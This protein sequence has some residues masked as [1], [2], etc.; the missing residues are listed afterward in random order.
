MSS[1][2]SNAAAI[3]FAA[4]LAIASAPYSLV[5]ML[6]ETLLHSVM[7]RFQTD[8][9]TDAMS[10]RNWPTRSQATS[11]SRTS[12]SAITVPLLPALGL[13]RRLSALAHGLGAI[14]VGLQPARHRRGREVVEHLA[15]VHPARRVRVRGAV[16]ELQDLARGHAPAVVAQRARHEVAAVDEDATGPG[17]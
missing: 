16:A 1:T 8:C 17:V 9:A 6:S 5:R 11:S 12:S 4:S 7:L 14:E 3:A 15:E 10:P 2:L 13:S